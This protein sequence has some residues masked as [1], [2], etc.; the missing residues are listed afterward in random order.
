MRIGVAAS[1]LKAISQS[2]TG[3]TEAFAHIL[4]EGLVA[5]GLDVTLFATSDS[6]TKAKLDSIVSSQQTTGVYEGSVEIRLAYQMLQATEIIKRAQEFDI[7]HNNYFHFF[8]LTSLSA[9]TNVPIVTT[10]HNHYWQY[11][12]L[13]SILTKT[14]IRGKDM[15]VFASQAARELGGNLF[16]SE[17]IYHGIDIS[18]FAFNA[19]SE[20][21]ALFLSRVVPTKGIKD[22]ID[23]AR[24]GDFELRIAGGAAVTPEDKHFI[25]TNVEPFYSDKIKNIGS[26]D[27]VLRKRLYQNAKALIFPTHLEEQFGLVAAEAMA[28]GTPV[29][30]YNH[31][32]LPEVVQ[33]GVTGFIIDP[34]DEERPGKGSW[35]IKKQGVEGLIEAVSRIGEIDRAACRKRVEDNF[36]RELM[37]NRYIDLYERLLGKTKTSF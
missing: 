9:F 34:D 33:D 25:S 22:A 17:V 11:P 28:C 16:D 32:A 10:M 5:K 24:I 14:Q 18:L 35:V 37:I 2:S 19:Q 20:E 1:L 7:I 3:G 12:N 26:P 27:D 4:T 23:A 8:V 31:G 36:T 13:K 6:N 30:A 29:I 21:Y 15:V